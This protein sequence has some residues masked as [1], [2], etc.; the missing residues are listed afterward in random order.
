MK[1]AVLALG[2][3]VALPACAGAPKPAAPSL[4]SADVAKPAAAP[5]AAA[6]AP[7]D[8]GRGGD[9]LALTGA[10]SLPKIERTPTA[11]LR[12]NARGDLQAAMAGLAQQ[13]S[14]EAGTAFL[15]KRLGKPTWTEDGQKR[16]WVAK[17]PEGCYRLVL[18]ADG[19]ADLDGASKGQTTTLA[20]G[21]AQ[22]M[23]TGEIDTGAK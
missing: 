22:N 3:C 21:A 12:H 13:K 10:L 23:C 8:E 14:L 17:T 7:K 15:L 4:T 16:F 1:H 2:L 18:L 11:Q 6:P 5:Q 20:P 9:P 19:T